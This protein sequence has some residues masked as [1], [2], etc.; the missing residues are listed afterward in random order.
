MKRVLV[1]TLVLFLAACSDTPTAPSSLPDAQFDL[2][3]N[4]AENSTLE[5]EV[6]LD[7]EE[8]GINFYKYHQNEYLGV[9]FGGT[10]YEIL[11][12]DPT[13]GFPPHSGAWVALSERNP[14]TMQITFP[15][16]PNGVDLKGMWA[17]TGYAPM[18]QLYVTFEGFFGDELVGLT[19]ATQVSRTA[20]SWIPVEFTGPVTRVVVYKAL[21]NGPDN[22]MG[23]QAILHFDDL[24]FVPVPLNQPPVADAGEDQVIE[25]TGPLTSVQL[26]ATESWDPDGDNLSYS[27][28]IDDVAMD[29]ATPTVTL[30][31]GTYAAQLLVDDG[32]GATATDEVTIVVEDNTAPELVFELGLDVLWPPNDKMVTVATGISAADLVSGSISPEITVVSN[33]GDDTD[34]II[35]DNGDGSFDVMLRAKRAG[36]GPDRIYTIT[37]TATDGEGNSV[38]Q[39]ESVVVPHDLGIKRGK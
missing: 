30:G 26:D 37:V 21:W 29:G 11:G 1:A 31:L 4:Q 32:N 38:T 18:L 7:F 15:G 10:V 19:D 36:N 27:W 6:V 28:T 13:W 39:E 25:A 16:Y 9:Q 34:W 33:Q 12:T 2:V 22:Y 5:V 3:A 8:P 17:G 14:A 35:V 23:D 24:T 20:M